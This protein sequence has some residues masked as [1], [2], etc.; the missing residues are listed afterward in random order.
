[1]KKINIVILLNLFFTLNIIAI[2]YD[3]TIKNAKEYY[4]LNNFNSLKFHKFDK[5]TLNTDINLKIKSYIYYAYP[6]NNQDCKFETG[7]KF[8]YFKDLERLKFEKKEENLLRRSEILF[9]GSL[10]F[11]AF[12]SWFFFSV[13]NALIYGEPFGKIRQEQFVPLFAGSALISVSIVLTDLLVRVRPKLK[14]VEIY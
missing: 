6:N 7:I 1:M 3:I 2:N 8:S 10:T 12:G 13:F 11:S 9:F 5:Y 4:D 14:N